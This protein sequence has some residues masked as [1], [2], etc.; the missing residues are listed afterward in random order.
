LWYGLPF[1]IAV[2]ERQA[3]IQ[4][5]LQLCQ[6]DL[7]HLQFVNPFGGF[8]TAEFSFLQPVRTVSKNPYQKTS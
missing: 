7:F 8:I 4:P 6:K 2:A 3:V 5:N 1:C